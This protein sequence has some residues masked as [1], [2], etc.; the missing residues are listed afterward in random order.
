MDSHQGNGGNAHGGQGCPLCALAEQ[1][2]RPWAAV[3]RWHCWVRKAAEERW[4]RPL[5]RTFWGDS[6][7]CGAFPRPW[8]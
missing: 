5:C 6:E 8:R 2:R 1:R 7:M 3:W 4:R